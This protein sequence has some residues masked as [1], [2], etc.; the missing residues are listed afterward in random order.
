[1]RY[2]VYIFSAINLYAGARFLLNALVILQTSKYGQ[3]SNVFF[4]I[5]L[6]T[7]GVVAFYV[8]IARQN[9]SLAL[10]I[11]A[12]RWILTLLLLVANMIFGDYK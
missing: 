9:H 12:S 2:V 7:A 11:D 1:M 5:T 4:A 3:G 6:T 8:S 10:L